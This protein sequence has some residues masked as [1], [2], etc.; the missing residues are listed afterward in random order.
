M[1]RKMFVLL[2][3]GCLSLLAAPSGSAG[4]TYTGSFSGSVVASCFAGTA[5][6]DLAG[7]V[8]LI[9]TPSLAQPGTYVISGTF[10]NQLFGGLS[11]CGGIGIG[12]TMTASGNEFL[13]GNQVTF[14]LGT[15]VGIIGTA[16]GTFSNDT[17]V[18]SGSWQFSVLQGQFLAS[19]TF[20]ASAPSCQVTTSAF[21]Q[22]DSRWSGI[23]Y[24]HTDETIGDGGCALTALAMALSAV[25][26]YVDPDAL[27]DQ[28]TNRP[29]MYVPFDK[30]GCPTSL[31][32]GG[33]LWGQAAA[34]ASNGRLKLF[35]MQI[36]ASLNPAAAQ[37][38]FN[39]LDSALCTA[40]PHPVIIGV[41]GS[42]GALPSHYELVTG[43]VGI[44]YTVLNPGFTNPSTTLD[45]YGTEFVTRGFIA[46]PPG[47]LSQLTIFVGS[48]ADL[49]VTD[50]D[51]NVTGLIDPAT[52]QDI[53]NIPQSAHFVDALA[54]DGAGTL[55]T[56]GQTHSVYI[57][58]PMSG[59]YSV[60]VIG[61][62]LGGYTLQV[63]AVSQDGNAQ[64]VTQISG[65]ANYG[66]TSTFEIQFSNSIGAVSS[67]IRLATFQS[68]LNDIS[69]SLQL[70]LIDN[71]GIANSL[72]KKIE[73]ASNATGP[74]R[75]NI[76]NAFKNEVNAQSGK[77]INGIAPQVL[78]EDA[79][80]LIGQ[81]SD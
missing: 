65:V 10:L 14:A 79:N 39:Y 57:L 59:A 51:G 12:F 18:L 46:D 62:K 42:D 11:P 71:N 22:E 27:N 80:S 26:V 69:N 60:N 81:I 78:E 4:V 68:T 6:A 47:D 34:S 72:S 77:H 2:L 24:D 52:G 43:K 45:R 29:G 21:S 54:N 8:N 17:G 58:E 63:A 32:C 33:L 40:I 15:V 38:A 50:P 55:P 53:Q 30:K 5:S 44:T 3:L 23:A 28:L 13:P 37:A 67:A 25:G 66:S 48:G 36:N 35:P 75:S 73:A 31:E 70:A 9:F 16:T 7:P 61:I 76:L 64:P 41:R 19:G 56:I 74:A 49:R 1:T 20:S